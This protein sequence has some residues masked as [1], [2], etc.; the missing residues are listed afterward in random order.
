MVANKQEIKVYDCHSGKLV[1]VHQN[2][3]DIAEGS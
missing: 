2:L 3:A 1:K